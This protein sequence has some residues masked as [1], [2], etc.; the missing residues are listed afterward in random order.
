MAGLLRLETSFAARKL[1]LGYRHLRAVGGIWDG[2]LNGHEFHYANTIKAQGAPL[3]KAK[4]T[5]GEA[6]TDM[7]LCHASVSGSFAHVIERV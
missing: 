4:N 7:D 5:E 1:D 2:N 3:F 6:L